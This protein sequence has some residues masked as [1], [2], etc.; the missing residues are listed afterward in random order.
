MK[1][2]LFLTVA[3]LIT[4]S[5]SN[6][7]TSKIHVT[8]INEFDTINPPKKI[9]VKV[10]EYGFLGNHYLRE[11]DVIHCNVI[12]VTDPKRGKRN[13]SFTV[14]PVSYTS[15]GETISIEESYYGK[16]APKII[17]K[18]EIKNIDKVQVGKKAVKTVGGFFVKGVAPAMSLAEGMVKNEEGNMLESGVKQVYKD[19][20]FSYV[21][22]GQELDL[23]PGEKFYLIFKPAKNKTSS[24]I[25]ED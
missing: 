21:E 8:A 4:I 2:L 24:D 20:P 5:V 9:D 17:S 10:I 23:E 13:A 18:E 7:E 15:N 14:S 16:Y 12:K 3:L 11:G 1:K 25:D 6:A 19:S 22:K